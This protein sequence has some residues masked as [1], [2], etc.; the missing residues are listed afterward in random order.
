MSESGPVIE[1]GRVHP[2]YHVEA[3]RRRRFK[4]DPEEKDLLLPADPSTLPKVT[5]S[6]SEDRLTQNVI[7]LAFAPP[8]GHR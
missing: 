6:A 3:L 8:K 7:D 4:D 1:A 2:D 5:L